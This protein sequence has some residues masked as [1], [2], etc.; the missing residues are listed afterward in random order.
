MAV[1][2]ADRHQATKRQ[3][4]HIAASTDRGRTFTKYAGNPVLDVDRR[5]FGDPKAF[6]HG[7]TG[8]WVMVNIEGWDQGRVLLYGSDDLKHWDFL[9]EFAAPEAAPGRWECPDLFPLAVDN[10]PQQTRWVMKVNV[11]TGLGSAW[12]VG[13][14]DGRT[15]VAD[16]GPPLRPEHGTLYA[17]VTYNDIPASDGRR[18]LMGWIR[19]KADDDRSWT[20]TQSVP[21]VLSL[22]S[23]AEGLRIC[24]QPVAEL[25][26]LRAEHVTVTNQSVTPGA[27]C[28][29]LTNARGTLLEIAA[30]FRVDAAR[31]VGLDVFKGADEYTRVGY[32]THARCLFVDRPGAER[33]CVRR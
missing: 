15:F 14:F 17:E 2:T 11:C 30:R 32:D 26:C 33:V 25:Q 10:D 28:A 1:Y 8:R 13:R 22:R 18:I 4:Q 24:Q 23:C 21:R 6:W 31:E 16:P 5:K 12:F 3:N 19:Q 9:S 7:P 20:G 29:A 27:E